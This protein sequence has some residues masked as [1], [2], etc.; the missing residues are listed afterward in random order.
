[1][2]SSDLVE[3]L[4]DD[5]D[6]LDHAGGRLDTEFLVSQEVAEVFAA[7]QVDGRGSVAWPLRVLRARRL[8]W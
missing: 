1:M 2:T 7:D 6:V 5:V 4:L 3:E 8:P